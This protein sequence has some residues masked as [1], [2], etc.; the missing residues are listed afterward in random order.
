MIQPTALVLDHEPT[1]LDLERST[2]GGTAL[3]WIERLRARLR[4]LRQLRDDPH[5]P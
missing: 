4:E 1:D 2:I 3:P 5:C